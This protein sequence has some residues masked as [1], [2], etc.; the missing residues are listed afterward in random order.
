MRSALNGV[1]TDFRG[2]PAPDEVEAVLR[3]FSRLNLIDEIT[4]VKVVDD[5]DTTKVLGSLDRS[6]GTTAV[7]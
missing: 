3:D 7:R 6:S 1:D 5:T 2:D 4:M